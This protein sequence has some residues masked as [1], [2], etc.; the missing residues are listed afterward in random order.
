MKTL[1]EYRDEIL[2]SLPATTLEEQLDIFFEDLGEYAG[3]NV[4]R[5]GDLFVSC[6]VISAKLRATIELDDVEYEGTPRNSILYLAGASVAGLVAMLA[7][8]FEHEEDPNVI[9]NGVIS[10]SKSLAEAQGWV[11]TDLIRVTMEADL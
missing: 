6:V 3:G 5:L 11:F 1:Q 4:K 10:L 7:E 9:F 2:A 8:G